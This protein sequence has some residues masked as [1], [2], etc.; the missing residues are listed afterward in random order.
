[1]FLRDKVT[2]RSCWTGRG[3]IIRSVFTRL[4]VAAGCVA[5]VAT[6][7]LSAGDTA[8]QE[9]QLLDVLERARGEADA[10]GG[11]LGVQA[12]GG[13]PVVV[14]VGHVDLDGK[15]RLGPDQPYFLGSVSKTYTAAVVLRLVEEG[16]LK[17]EDPLEQWI[18]GF[19]RAT[20]M[21]VR[22]LLQ[23]TTGLKDFYSYIY[24]RP[25]RA[26][27]E[28]LVTR[29]WTEA[30]LL[31]L[32]GRFGHWFSP[33]GDWSYSSANY[34]LLGVVIERAA[35]L[36]LAEAYRTFLYAPAGLERTWLTWHEE[37]AGE[38][39]PG[40]MGTIEEWEHSEMFG[41]IGATTRLD[42]SPVEW[43]AGGLAA[44]AA[45]ALRFLGG[46]MRGELLSEA[47]LEEM[48]DFRETPPLGMPARADADAETG[49]GY[50]LGLVRMVRHGLTFIGHG[51][52]FTG[53]TA[54]LWYVPECD[55]VISVYF[56]RGFVGHR[57]LLDRV[58]DLLTDGAI[59]D[60][61]GP[62]VSG[63]KP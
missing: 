63:S 56:N 39:S 8:S 25:E 31:Q 10:P 9:P 32:A 41:E 40:F 17:L 47:S 62:S 26:E 2:E 24:F 53:H 48:K 37:A 38:L 12:G 45:D 42:R 29:S 4:R 6:L 43:G 52:L 36:T 49:N 50:G 60:G 44:P 18:P 14:S 34:Y 15:Q 33:G 55:A 57:D 46:L 11:I 23:H 5:L 27:M 20:E 3:T 61:C 1:M 7:A 28:R 22:Q 54:G 16:L 59:G 35:G 13:P 19:P 30:E 21:S 58:A 51:G